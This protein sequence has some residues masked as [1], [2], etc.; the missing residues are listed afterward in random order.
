MKIK[1]TIL[2]KDDKTKTY[3]C[4]DYPSVGEWI[5]LCMPN[6]ERLI[7]PKEGVAEIKYEVIK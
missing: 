5:W 6:L 4:V 2:Y 3:I 7:I 1:V